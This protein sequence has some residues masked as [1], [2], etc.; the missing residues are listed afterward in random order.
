MPRRCRRSSPER[1]GRVRDRHLG[2]EADV[3]RR[4]RHE[5]GDRARDREPAPLERRPDHGQERAAQQ[6]GPA[7]AERPV[8]VAR[9][10]AEGPDQQERGCQRE[11]QQG[12]RVAPGRMPELRRGQ[13]DACSHARHGE[14]QRLARQCAHARGV[15]RLAGAVAHHVG[16]APARL[17]ERDGGETSERV[18]EAT[19]RAGCHASPFACL[20]RVRR[21][22]TTRAAA[23]SRSASWRTASRPP[24]VS[25]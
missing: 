10:E 11:G 2:P 3:G 6:H 21:T 1:A 13:T 14:R 8:V 23:A 15:H 12:Q 18:V 4:R 16:V 25:R 20:G 22:W 5:Y 9:D 19:A 24:S 7:L 17:R